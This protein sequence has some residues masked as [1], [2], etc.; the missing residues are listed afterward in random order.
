[1]FDTSEWKSVW[2]VVAKKPLPKQPPI[3]SEFMQLLTQLG[4]YNNHATEAP[5]G[6]LPLWIGLRRMNAFATVWLAF[7]P[8]D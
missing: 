4:G 1:M 2:R 8:I 5:A 7:G 3:L 6:P